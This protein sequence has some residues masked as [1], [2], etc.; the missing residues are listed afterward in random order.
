MVK[1]EVSIKQQFKTWLIAQP[2]DTLVNLLPALAQRD[3]HLAQTLPVKSTRVDGQDTLV[4]DLRLACHAPRSV[5]K[6]GQLMDELGETEQFEVYGAE[7]PSAFKPKLNFIK[8][9]NEVKL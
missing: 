2:S 5:R 9:L 1:K 6:V 3:D 8:L 7:L 4:A